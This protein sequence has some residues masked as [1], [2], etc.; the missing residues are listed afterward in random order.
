[1]ESTYEVEITEPDTAGLDTAGLDTAG[2][3]QPDSDAPPAFI[4]LES[5]D[6]SAACTV[7][8]ECL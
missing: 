2:P 4:V 8:G 7:D 3:E 6:D 1:M 5:A